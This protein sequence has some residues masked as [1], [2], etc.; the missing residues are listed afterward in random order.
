MLN[1]F[2]ALRERA[3]YLASLPER[4][5]RSLASVAGGTTTLLT[6]TLF[7]EVLR[8]TTLY[9][10][11]VGDTQKFVIEKVAQIH[12]EGEADPSSSDPQYLQKK[13]VGGA[14]E[15]AGLFA[16]HFSPLWIFAIA[17][18][19]AG[20][21]TVFLQRLVDQLKTNGVIDAD[22][23]VGNLTDALEAMQETSRKSV[24][25]IDTPPLSREK[26][27]Q[28]A[29]EMTE[30]YKGMFAKTTDLLPRIEDI[31]N[32]M[33]SLASKENVSL[34]HITGI[35]TVD[36]ASWGK[37]GIGAVM[38]VGRTGADLF[39]EKVLDSY[40]NTLSTVKDE[41][42]TGYLD[43]RMQPFIQAAASH[44]NPNRKTWTESLLG[45]GEQE[46]P[47]LVESTETPDAPPLPADSDE[48]AASDKRIATDTEPAAQE[49][50]PNEPLPPPEA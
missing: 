35:L 39:G 8:D 40:A 4:T 36:V 30:S 13:M 16:M 32:Q 3:T 12:K 7:P 26:L 19:A 1:F 10:I 41:G 31:W 27:S 29:V 21:G 15:T 22:A 50:K 46:E 37:K 5:I 42:V 44:F 43:N 48:Q 18:D 20:G 25:A 17:G 45:T 23:D 49:L 14:L 33:N 28:L 38:A 11:F 24:F 47:P 6:E 9:R 2:K 34:E